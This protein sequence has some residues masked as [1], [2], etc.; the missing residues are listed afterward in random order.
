MN[1]ADNNEKVPQR[2]NTIAELQFLSLRIVNQVIIRTGFASWLLF[3]SF[4]A[5]HLQPADKQ[6]VFDTVRGFLGKLS[7]V[8][9]ILQRHGGINFKDMPVPLLNILRF[10]TFL[11]MNSKINP[12]QVL[13]L[14]RMQGSDFFE[15]YARFIER[16]MNFVAKMGMQILCEETAKLPPRERIAIQQSFPQWIVELWVNAFGE[17]FTEELCTA[18]NERPPQDL[19]VNVAKRSHERVK[20][21][22]LR[23]NVPCEVGTI[24]PHALVVPN[25]IEVFKTK[26]FRRALFEM[27][28]QG[29]QLVTYLVDLVPGD[30]VLDYCAGNGGK[31]LQLASLAYKLDP[32]P[33]IYASDISD[34]K[35]ATLRRRVKR[36]FADTSFIK[37]VSQGDLPR[38][39]QETRFTKILVDAP[40]SGLGNIRRKPGIKAT[41]TLEDVAQL[42]EKQAQILRDVSALSQVHT[43]LIYVTCTI[44]PRENEEQI[45]LFVKSD[46][47][48]V[49]IPFREGLRPENPIS[50]IKIP[51]ISRVDGR[52]F[53]LYPPLTQTEGFFG[54]I[55]AKTV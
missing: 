46:P 45:T 30:V 25:G 18:S 19:R 55:L 6:V 3:K 21:T 13:G 4:K 14:A 37:V 22:L 54:A 15:K 26:S 52:F 41:S 20:N 24:A 42:V 40:C 2:S 8:E 36:A 51:V 33:I 32:R 16:V 47:S 35:L 5:L 1:P 9:F 38:I 27:Q 7:T 49:V 39:A 43:R 29:S 34:R 50:V 12:R 17:V 53:T 23:E 31:T 28:D 11:V 48:F 10:G 44:D